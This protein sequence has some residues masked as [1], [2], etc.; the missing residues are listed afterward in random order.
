MK[1]I[2]IITNLLF[3][4][5]YIVPNSFAMD[6]DLN[7]VKWNKIL[8]KNLIPL[9]MELLNDNEM[10]S[11]T[12]QSGVSVILESDDG[13]SNVFEVNV[14]ISMTSIGGL[15]GDYDKDSPGYI[16]LKSPDENASDEELTLLEISAKVANGSEMTM[17]SENSG[18]N[19]VNIGGSAAFE[20]PP[21]TPYLEVSI[22][23]IKLDVYVAEDMKIILDEIESGNSPKAGVLGILRLFDLTIDLIQPL[24]P[25]TGKAVGSVFIYP[26]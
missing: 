10:D 19:G 22:P 3:F 13:D 4:L 7:I 12:A 8:E 5:I 15:L 1:K 2:Y 16:V 25:K 24:D 17:K 14:Q 18:P 21:N 9:D 11:V 20:I 23:D 26:S 6:M